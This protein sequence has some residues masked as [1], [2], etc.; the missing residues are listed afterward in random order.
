[1]HI[2]ASS[3]QLNLVLGICAIPKSTVTAVVITKRQSTLFPKRILSAGDSS[4]T[5]GHTYSFS[6]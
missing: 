6:A 2:R 5:T 3:N 1:M 4:R